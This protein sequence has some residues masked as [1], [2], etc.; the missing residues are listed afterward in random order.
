MYKNEAGGFTISNSGMPENSY[1][2]HGEQ[3][4]LQKESKGQLSLFEFNYDP[5]SAYRIDEWNENGPTHK[6]FAVSGKDNIWQIDEFNND[7]IYKST[8][9]L[10]LNQIFEKEQELQQDLNS[11]GVLGNAISIAYQPHGG[12]KSLYKIA[13]G[14]FYFYDQGW[15]T[16]SSF[17]NQEFSPGQNKPIKANVKFA[18]D[19]TAA[20]YNFSYDTFGN[21]V[22]EIDIY[23]GSGDKW[24]KETFNSS[25]GSILG[26]QLNMISLVFLN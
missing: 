10:N 1:L 4:L 5:S 25:T 9:K 24:V 20:L 15:N 8:Q 7:G 6:N 19:P 14:E 18:H 2:D 17:H 11:D 22:D 13:S 3:I 21:I 12:N 23:H 16:G 26:N